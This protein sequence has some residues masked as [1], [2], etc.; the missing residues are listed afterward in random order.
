MSLNVKDASGTTRTLKTTESGG[1]HSP[2][3]RVDVLAAGASADI[4]ATTDSE[5]TGNGSLIGILKR[6]RTLLGGTLT[7]NASGAA[8]PVT[9]NSST[10]SVDDGG[11]SLTV[12]GT[13]AITGT[14]AVTDNSSTL[15]VDDGGGS[16]TVDGTVGVSG[17]VA[18]TDNSGSLTVDDG[19][20]SLTVDGTV[21]VSGEVDVTPA[22][23]SASAYLP[24]RLTNGSTFYTAD[25]GGDEAVVA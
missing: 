17:T 20:S 6:I 8:V 18:V 3:H 15:S 10:L 4:G 12:D 24:V 21:S 13:V 2:H 23:P 14:V 7:V 11:G 22:S 5:A 9:D 19:G 16:I 25:G 1:E